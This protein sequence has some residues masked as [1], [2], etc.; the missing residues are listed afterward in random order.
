MK[1]GWFEANKAQK[2]FMSMRSISRN[3]V[4]G[5]IDPES[6]RDV[7]LKLSSGV[8][9]AWEADVKGDIAE[10]GTGRRGRTASYIAYAMQRHGRFKAAPKRL[11]LF[12]SFEG[13]P[14]AESA[15]DRKTPHV[16]SGAWGE[17]S[18][19]GIT[20]KRLRSIC[21][22]FLPDDKV[23]IYDGW[24]RDTLPKI[25]QKTKFCL[26]HIDCELYQSAME[27]LDHLLGN[28]MVSEGAL[29][30]FYA[31]SC[32]HSSPDY[33]ERKA[34]KDSIKKYSVNYTDSGEFGWGG[35]KFVVHSYSK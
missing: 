9:Y 4:R 13:M 12:D 18:C 8:E 15:V 6:E 31:F 26:V 11:H 5:L 34:W 32:N 30:Y 7:R 3:A 21:S 27:V 1:K 35:R 28:K 19:K 20:K 29:V 24:F 14:K 22:K 33:G 23:I 2:I 17:G 16:L 10:F 25:S